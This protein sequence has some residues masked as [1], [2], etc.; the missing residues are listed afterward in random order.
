IRVVVRMLNNNF[1]V[2]WEK[3][4][5]VEASVFIFHGLSD[6]WRI[7]P[8]R[9]ERS[10]R[11][12]GCGNGDHTQIPFVGPDGYFDEFGL[13]DDLD[14]LAFGDGAIGSFRT[15]GSGRFGLIVVGAAVASLLPES[16]KRST[17]R[18][19]EDQK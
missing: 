19:Q 8:I 11:D 15:C 12:Y 7:F 10:Q 5:Q 18:D 6:R 14:P 13:R 3:I 16:I 17:A 9:R 4:D 2:A 1:V